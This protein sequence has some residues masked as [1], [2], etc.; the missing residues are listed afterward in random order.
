MASEDFIVPNFLGELGAYSD[1]IGVKLERN[2]SEISA[3]MTD[4]ARKVDRLASTSNDIQ[5]RCSN[6]TTMMIGM[7]SK[8][9]QL[10]ANDVVVDAIITTMSKKIVENSNDTAESL[11]LA[12]MAVC[13]V[14]DRVCGV[15][16]HATLACVIIVVLYFFA[17]VSESVAS[18]MNNTEL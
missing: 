5:E 2:R 14:S 16:N 10:V 9:K 1:D 4:V 7:E 8:L 17:C 18:L 3:M 11:R 12:T 6:M 15:I 13:N